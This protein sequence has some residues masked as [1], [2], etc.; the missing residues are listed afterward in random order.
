MG[1]REIIETIGIAIKVAITPGTEPPAPDV[2][3]PRRRSSVGPQD[4]RSFVH[5]RSPTG[6]LYSKKRVMLV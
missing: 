1:D 3:L 6:P 2:G 4:L 5:V